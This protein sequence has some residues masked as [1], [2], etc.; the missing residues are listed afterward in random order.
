MERML[1]NLLKKIVFLVFWLNFKVREGIWGQD[2]KMGCSCH[3]MKNGRNS[4]SKAWEI[5]HFYSFVSVFHLSF[6]KIWHDHP[7]KLFSKLI[8]KKI[9]YLTKFKVLKLKIVV[10]AGIW[11]WVIF[12]YIFTIIGKKALGGWMVVMVTI[13]KDFINY[14]ILKTSKDRPNTPARL[15]LLVQ[16]VHELVV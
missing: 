9:Y 16:R 15:K 12:D 8:G 11:N 10:S 3:L 13:Q 1:Q 2:G 5:E 6:P 7:Q 14:S 4:P